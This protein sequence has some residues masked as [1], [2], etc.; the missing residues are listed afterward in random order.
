MIRIISKKSKHNYF[1]LFEFIDFMSGGALDSAV[2]E[3]E[4]MLDVEV[5][6]AKYIVFRSQNLWSTFILKY[7]SAY[8][9][10]SSEI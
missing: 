9:S 2:N 1:I 8:L 5:Q 7:L 10:T 3:L 6:K 4:S